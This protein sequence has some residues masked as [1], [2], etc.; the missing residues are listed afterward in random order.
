M[1]STS[2]LV[3]YIGVWVQVG[4]TF[5]LLTLFYVLARHAGTRPYFIR[6]SWAWLAMLVGLASVGAR[7][8]LSP[9]LPTEPSLL[10]FVLHSSYLFAKLVFLGFLVSGTWLFCEGRLPPGRPLYWLLGAGVLSAA[11][12]VGTTTMTPIMLAQ[13]PVAF[14]AYALLAI[15]LF[16]LPV[17]RRTMGT[18]LTAWVMAAQSALWVLY[19]ATFWTEYFGLTPELPWSALLNTANSYFDLAL[20]T[21]MVIG[22]VVILLEDTQRETEQARAERLGA[23]AESEARLKAVIETAT[24]GIVAAD[25]EGRIVLANAGA[26]RLF[27]QR[28]GEMVGHDLVEYFPDQSQAEL[29]RRLTE[30]R[31]STPGGH[32][33]FEVS[34]L[35]PDGLEVPL[36]VAASTLVR[37][38]SVLEILILRDLTDRR[39]AESDREQLQSRLAQSVRMEALGRLVSGVAHELNNP[40]AAILTFSEQLLAEQAE[41]EIAGPIRTIREQARRARAIVR[42]LLTFVRRREERREP[43]EIGVLVERTVRALEADLSR[44]AVS[45]ALTTE[46][47]LPLLHCDPTAVE[48]VLTNLLDNAARAAPGGTVSLTIRRDRDGVAIVVEDSG[49]GIPPAHLT[50]IF[51]PFFTTRGTGEGTGLGL[52]V[53][54]G[55]VQQHG[56]ELRAENRDPGP[57]A[58]FVAW[59]PCGLLTAAAS[60]VNASG[61]VQPIS[62]PDG[63]RGQVLIIDDEDAVRASMR[64]YFERQGWSVDEASDGAVGLAKLLATRDHTS[65]DLVICDLK[66]PGLTGLELHHWV[67]ASR[68]DLLNRLVF[69]SGDT[70][71]P[72][73]SAFLSSS[74]CPVLEKPFELRELAAVIA[75]VRE[76]RA[77]VA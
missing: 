72:E 54:L 41:A 14:G 12:S 59:L 49:P 71:S 62:V 7:Y 29:T 3:S 74:G 77:G 65:Y 15:M 8:L 39:R 17:E 69:A 23:V 28:R 13:Q 57:G 10:T 11:A 45:L 42:D 51:E 73:A 22:M 26:A 60:P 67:S 70:A 64:R 25:G 21:V 34:G 40:L 47:G 1:N 66:M 35:A 46:P 68:P 52:S 5:L 48:Q 32:L 43:A 2:D 9:L 55:I 19:G 33:V 30:M 36:E 53:S 50:R 56:G 18:R 61:P 58:R 6:W 27:G 24:D 31:R 20:G 75:R 37:P 44:Q 63:E 38:G 16:R 76:A 4:G